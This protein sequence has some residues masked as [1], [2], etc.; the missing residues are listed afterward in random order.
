M[1]RKSVWCGLGLTSCEM[2][3]IWTNGVLIALLHDYQ[4]TQGNTRDDDSI[5]STASFINH[6][7]ANICGLVG[8]INLDEI[9][10]AN[11]HKVIVFPSSSWSL[12]R[13][14]KHLLF[15]CVMLSISLCCIAV[16]PFYNFSKKKIYSIMSSELRLRSRFHAILGCAS[17]VNS[18]RDNGCRGNKQSSHSKSSSRQLHCLPSLSKHSKGEL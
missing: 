9:T 17:T 3:S 18:E 5:C 14:G 4:S 2:R 1:V 16:I 11:R 10:K 12:I 7:K 15:R 8:L 6:F 13:S